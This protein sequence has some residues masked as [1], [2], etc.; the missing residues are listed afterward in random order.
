MR[1]LKVSLKCYGTHINITRRQKIYFWIVSIRCQKGHLLPVEH[2]LQWGSYPEIVESHTEVYNKNQKKE[3]GLLFWHDYI[4]KEKTRLPSLALLLTHPHMHAISST[5]S[6]YQSFNL[7]N[8]RRSP[9]VILNHS[10]NSSN[11][12][13]KSCFMQSFFNRSHH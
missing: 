13:L 5:A 10:I 2:L 11:P 8:S 12:D 4:H 1:M 7:I 3:L 6:R 9:V